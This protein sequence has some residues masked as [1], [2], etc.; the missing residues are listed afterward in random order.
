MPRSD[1]TG[2]WQ[3]AGRMGSHTCSRGRNVLT[4][5][6]GL[7][8]VSV[9]AGPNPTD[10]CADQVQPP[11]TDESRQPE[12]GQS[13][14]S[15][16]NTT[17]VVTAARTEIPLTE[18]PASTTVVSQEILRMMPKAIAAE[19]ALQ[20]VP[21]VKVDNQANG[22]GFLLSGQGRVRTQM[23]LDGRSALRPDPDGNSFQPAPTRE[24]FFG[25]R[26]WLDSQ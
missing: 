2:K 7:F 1:R 4:R 5:L 11:G 17:V 24:V 6:L 15:G 13:Q 3:S 8:I 22:N 16:V 19:E 18:N 25:A 14:P 23:G 26:I 21:G 10:A 9:L 20:L 12:A